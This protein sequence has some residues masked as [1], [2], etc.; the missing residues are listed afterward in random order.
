MSTELATTA[1]PIDPAVVEQVLLSGD[2]RRL[3]PAQKVSYYNRVCESVGLN[4]LTQ[5]FAYLV[6]NGKEILYARK[7]CTEQL[8][9]QHTVSITIPARE[10]LEDVYVVTARASL[11]SGRTDE[12][13][14]AVAIAGLKGEARANALMKAETKAKRRVTLAICGLGLLDESEVESIDAS[15]TVDGAP[16]VDAAAARI[17]PPVQ[18]AQP[19]PPHMPAGAVTIRRVHTEPTRNPRVTRYLVLTSA[20]EELATVNHERA[21]RAEAARDANEPVFVTGKPT[22]YGTDLVDIRPAIPADPSLPLE[23]PAP[24]PEPPT[25]PAGAMLDADDI[26]F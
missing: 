15:Y 17:E 10:L 5:P 24:T 14:G 4:P 12:S 3:S 13:I 20:G 7:E 1:T 25:P 22:Q 11:P 8:R 6:L 2:L 23:S 18:N 21:H 16:A 19:T 26:P 9:R